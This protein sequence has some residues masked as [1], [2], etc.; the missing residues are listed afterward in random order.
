[1]AADLRIDPDAVGDLARLARRIADDLDGLPG[2][3]G[4]VRR[5]VDDLLAFTGAAEA[6]ARR[7][8][9]ADLAAAARFR[10]PRR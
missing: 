10:E 6:A 8:R 1:M 4:P 3:D 5:A 9:D 2:V 7:A